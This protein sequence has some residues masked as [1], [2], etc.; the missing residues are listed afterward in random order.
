MIS[1]L[2][3]GGIVCVSDVRFHVTEDNVVRRTWWVIYSCLVS[4]GVVRQVFWPTG[5]VWTPVLACTRYAH[6]QKFSERVRSVSDTMP[7]PL[8]EI[9]QWISWCPYACI[10]VRRN[11]VLIYIILR[12]M[13]ILQDRHDDSCDQQQNVCGRW[14]WRDR[15]LERQ[16]RIHRRFRHQKHI[17]K[18]DTDVHVLA[19]NCWRALFLN[20]LVYMYIH[21]HDCT[22]TVHTCT[23]LNA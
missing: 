18:Y 17:R 2:L 14:S 5:T 6:T 10:I 19:V 1:E 15:R 7:A 8:V 20:W 4:T 21:V 3:S 16:R 13:Y 11:S 23:H 12:Y 22:C 9:V